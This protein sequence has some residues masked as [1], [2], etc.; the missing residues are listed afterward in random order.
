[1]KK[2][3]YLCGLLMLTG[4]GFWGC[5][6]TCCCTIVDTSINIHFIDKDGRDLIGT[7]ETF[8]KENIDVYYV[9]NGVAE[10][11]NNP[12][13]DAPENFLI[14]DESGKKVFRLFPNTESDVTL[15][16]IGFNKTIK[17][18]VECKIKNLDCGITCSEVKYN[19]IVK[20]NND[21]KARSFDLVK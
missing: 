15:T 18:T 14:F 3:Q 20:W 17:D 5:K 7:S 6:K 13:L 11:V 4:I 16:I 9:K 21:G 10:K 1:M 2:T 19:G 12:S 8:K